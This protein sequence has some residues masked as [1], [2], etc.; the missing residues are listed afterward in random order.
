MPATSETLWLMQHVPAGIFVLCDMRGFLDEP[1][2]EAEN[3][4]WR[5]VLER[6]NVNVTPG[7]ACRI[8]EPGF[9]RLCYA[10]EPV[11]RVLAGIERIGRLLA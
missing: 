1:T 2:W 6:A 7:S 4:L 10:A 11:D 9:M 5:H 3:A 8:V